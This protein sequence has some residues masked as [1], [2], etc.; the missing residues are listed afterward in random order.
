MRLAGKHRNPGMAVGDALDHTNPSVVS[1]LLH[2][3]LQVAVYS[4]CCSV[5]PPVKFLGHKE[6]LAACSPQ[7]QLQLQVAPLSRFAASDVESVSANR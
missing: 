2:S 4:L 3:M 6:V 7:L 5:F 1:R